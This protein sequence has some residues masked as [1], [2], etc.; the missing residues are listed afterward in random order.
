MDPIIQ[1]KPTPSLNLRCA[2][3]ALAVLATAPTQAAD[4]NG[5]R[6]FVTQLYSHYPQREGAPEFDPLGRAATAVFDPALVALIRK[7][8]RRTPPGDV[9]AIDGDPICDCQDDGGLSVKIGAIRSTGPSQAAASVDLRFGEASPPETRRLELDLVV[10]QGRWRVHD[11][12]T[13][14]TPSLRAYLIRSMR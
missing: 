12:R 11:V 3:T 14:D 9:G 5:A 4:L 10:V 6:A 7:D 1:R 8:A 2:I 13:K